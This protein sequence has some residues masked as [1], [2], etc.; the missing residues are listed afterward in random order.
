MKNEKGEHIV[1]P[2]EI[3]NMIIDDDFEG[4]ESVTTDFT[5][6]HKDYSITFNKQDLEIIN[7]WVFE[8]DTSIPAKL[9]EHL[10]ESIREEVKKRI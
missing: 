1:Q 7:L 5:H 2:Y 4:Q 8:Q 9:S 10:I 3:K 6:D